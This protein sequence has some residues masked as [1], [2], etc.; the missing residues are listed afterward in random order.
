ME[1]LFC[2]GSNHPEQLA[3]RIGQP[4]C[5]AAA[6]A[7]GHK[8]VFRGW[9]RNWEGGV[10]SLKAGKGRPAYGYVAT[11]TKAQLEHMDQFEGVARGNYSRKKIPVVVGDGQE[12]SAWAY[13]SNSPDFNQPSKRYLEAVAK[14][15]GTFWRIDS[16]RE[17]TVE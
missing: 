15:I 12:V 14:T 8:R 4:R 11:I 10:A 13:F 16:I 9:S 5:V 2:F 3:S 7:P 6:Y 1:L 17:I